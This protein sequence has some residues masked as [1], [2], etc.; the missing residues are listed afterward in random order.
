MI[1]SQYARRLL[2]PLAL[3]LLWEAASRL[4]YIT[5]GLLPAPSGILM[6]WWDWITGFQGTALD[7]S[8][9]WAIDAGASLRRVA[10]GYGLAVIGGVLIGIAMGWSNLA[11]ILMEPTLQILRPIPPVAWIPLAIIWFGVADPPAIFLVFLGSFFP[12]MMNTVYGVRAVDR[13]LV[14]A[15]EM[16]G[17]KPWQILLYIVFPAALPGIFAGLRIGIGSAW[18]LSVTAEM[19]AVRSGIGYVLWDSYYFVRYD[20][21]MAAMASI[22][23]L[24]YLSDLALR[25]LMNVSLRWQRGTTIAGK[26]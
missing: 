8:G 12:I 11:D 21:V 3:L 6:I 23:M 25:L 24:G 14:R 9:H 26:G 2:V 16:M 15:G 5:R 20:L 4:G 7:Y 1:I 22:G 18:M 13:N 17:A 19:V 10:C